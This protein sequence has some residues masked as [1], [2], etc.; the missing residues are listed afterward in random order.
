M[1]VHTLSAAALALFR[2]NLDRHGDLDADA[3]RAA[4]Q[5]LERSGLVAVGHS[6]RDG[7][8]SIYRLTK[9]GFERKAEPCGFTCHGSLSQTRTR[10]Q[11]H[12]VGS[13]IRTSTRHPS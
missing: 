1:K 2:L 7:R 10:Q 11:L 12:S 8:N 5:E 4:Y 6:F 3:N 9:E 13:T